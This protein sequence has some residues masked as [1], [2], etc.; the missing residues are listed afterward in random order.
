MPMCLQIYKKKQNFWALDSEV[1]SQAW[2][3]IMLQELSSMS[4]CLQEAF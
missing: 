4:M 1:Q 2:I 3:N